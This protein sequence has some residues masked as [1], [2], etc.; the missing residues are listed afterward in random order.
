MAKVGKKEKDRERERERK[1]VGFCI[2]CI[3]HDPSDL[4]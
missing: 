3:S 1:E 4:F 2:F